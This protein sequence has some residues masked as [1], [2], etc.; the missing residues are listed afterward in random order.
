MP[1]LDVADV[2]PAKSGVLREIVLIPLFR[3]AQRTDALPSPHANLFSCHPSSLD[4]SFW[5]YFA[6]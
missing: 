5:L 2:R 3:L 4:V 1:A 6:Y